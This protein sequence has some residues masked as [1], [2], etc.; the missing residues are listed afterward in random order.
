LPLLP[1]AYPLTKST[2]W[3]GTD[4]NLN[5]FFHPWH[6]WNDEPKFQMCIDCY[7]GW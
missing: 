2:N 7:V 3:L 1:P 6:F 4:F 5:Y